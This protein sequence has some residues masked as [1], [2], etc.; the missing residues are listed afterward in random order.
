VADGD[1]DLEDE[2][3]EPVAESISEAMVRD[4]GALWITQA[5]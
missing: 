5:G 1:D 3:P 4:G 2:E